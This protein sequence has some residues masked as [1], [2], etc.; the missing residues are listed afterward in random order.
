MPSGTKPTE[1]TTG[2]S[3]AGDAADPD[4]DALTYV[5]GVFP[6]D[7]KLDTELTGVGEPPGKVR[8]VRGGDIAALVSDVPADGSIGSARDL[9]A[10]KDILDASAS[11]VP[12]LPMRFGAVL[13]DDQAVA[14]D[15]LAA[16]HDAFAE[17]LA[18]LEGRVQYVVKG[19]YHER[20]L[21]REVLA[22]NRD[23]A[24]LREAIRQA[25]DRATDEARIRL[26]EMIDN[27]VAAKREQ[28]ARTLADRL[29]GHYE[30]SVLR[31]PRHERDA[32]Y[33]ALLVKISQSEELSQA[34]DDLAA[35]WRERM[36]L[37]LLGPMA[38]YDFVGMPEPGA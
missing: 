12:V 24:R 29:D 9:A 19:R 34:I 20:V 17:A 36:V 23:A 33:A 10:H 21:V 30:A 18:E 5:Y 35:E 14:D 13:A 28:E 32:I 26:G 1:D 3:G 37:R 38:A 31:E 16:N 2:Q 15:L 4:E 7:I 22:E 11:A 27:A 25:G 8:I 6:G